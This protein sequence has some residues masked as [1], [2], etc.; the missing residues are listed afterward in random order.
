MKVPHF[1]IKLEPVTADAKKMEPFKWARDD[2]GSRH[3]IG[4]DPDFIEGME[5]PTCDCGVEMTFYAQLD[6]LNE[7]YNIGD[8]GMIYI[9]LCF[10]CFISKSIVQSY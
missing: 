2:I 10:D 4:G 1:K 6:S 7:K 5:S 8:A 9:F 3:K